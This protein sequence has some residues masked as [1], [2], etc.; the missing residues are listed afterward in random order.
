MRNVAE[1]EPLQHS[2]SAYR[3]LFGFVHPYASID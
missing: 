1:C 2:R 3:H